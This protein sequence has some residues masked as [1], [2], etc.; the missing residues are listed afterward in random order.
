MLCVYPLRSSKHIQSV[1]L[2]EFFSLN[3]LWILL[4]KG[5]LAYF[6][7]P[8]NKACDLRNS[9]LRLFGGNSFT[10]HIINFVKS[11][12]FIFFHLHNCKY[13]KFPQILH[14][15][16]LFYNH[17]IMYQPVRKEP[18]SNK[19]FVYVFAAFVFC[20][21]ILL[22]SAS[23]L[24]IKKPELKLTSTTLNGIGYNDVSPSPFF[25]ATII[26][27]FSIW[28]PNYG[29]IFSYEYS[30][31][32]V[33]YSGVKVGVTKIPNDKVSQR[34]TKHIN[35]TVDVN[36]L[37]LIVNGNEKFSSDIGSG[38]LNLT[39]YVKFSG[40]VQLMKIFHKRKT[41]EM[42]CIMNLNFTSHAIQG[43]HCW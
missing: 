25:N 36:F 28:N 37:K 7:T 16:F 18:S 3:Q 8:N 22:I 5:D 30:N 10:S 38:M 29:G 33:L 39:S 12:V 2:L 41:L 43:I 6:I 15:R 13:T 42:A 4:I 24:R 35:V 23:I 34:K 40:I 26:T 11:F 19:C 14:R 20:C 9:C 17:R 32:K 21:A 27:Y 1:L 31:I